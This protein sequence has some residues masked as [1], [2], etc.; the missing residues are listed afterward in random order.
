M[1]FFD[2][3]IA[4]YYP[5][6]Y[7]ILEDLPSSYAYKNHETKIKSNFNHNLNCP[8]LE[9]KYNFVVG[10]NDSI[11]LLSNNYSKVLCR[12]SFHEFNQKNK[13]SSEQWEMIS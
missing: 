13:M 11:P 10:K 9:N 12:I 8:N 7:F 3:E 5:N 2:C 6:L 1:W 4:H